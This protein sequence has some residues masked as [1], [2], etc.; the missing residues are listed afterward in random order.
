MVTVNILKSTS[1]L[2]YSR[3]SSIKIFSGTCSFSVNG[4]ILTDR[5][6]VG[7]YVFKLYF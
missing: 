6:C 3:R 4:D 1:S 5:S 7:K 2:V